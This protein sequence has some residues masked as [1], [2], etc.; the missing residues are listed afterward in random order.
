LALIGIGQSLCDKL[1]NVLVF[2]LLGGFTRDIEPISARAT[3]AE[4]MKQQVAVGD[5]VIKT[6]VAKYHPFRAIE[7][8]KFIKKGV[9][10]C[11]SR[12]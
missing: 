1:F 9:N 10:N 6:S 12:L 5:T 2:E 4:Q 8:P 11:T 7:N 3:N